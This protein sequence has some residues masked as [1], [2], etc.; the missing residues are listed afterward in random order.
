MLNS[1]TVVQ[2]TDFFQNDHEICFVGEEEF[3]E[4]CQEDPLARSNFLRYCF[5]DEEDT[6]EFHWKTYPEVRRLGFQVLNSC[7]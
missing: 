3:E 5:K 1:L 6:A 2:K 7:D 4:N